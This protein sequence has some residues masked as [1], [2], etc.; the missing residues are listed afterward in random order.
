MHR[1]FRG[2]G[3]TYTNICPQNTISGD[4]FL[5]SS[6]HYLHLAASEMW[7]W[8]GGREITKLFVLQ[9][10]V[11]LSWCTMVRAVLTGRSTV[12]GFDLDLS[13]VYRHSATVLVAFAF[14]GPPSGTHSHKTYEAVT[15]PGNSSSVDLRHGCL[16]VLMCRWRVWEFFIEDALYK[17]TFWFD[18]ML[19]DFLIG[20][21]LCLPSDS[22]S[23]MF[24]VLCI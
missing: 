1:D 14:Q 16:S 17:F 6:S 10:Y 20:L 13:H 24:V 5:V 4:V 8:S 15:F 2:A 3:K 19:I 21:A 12:S 23:S 9:H 7:C 18:L 22:V 11:P